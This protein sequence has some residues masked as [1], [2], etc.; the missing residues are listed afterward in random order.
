[1]SAKETS[2]KS[3][4]KGMFSRQSTGDNKSSHKGTI[5]KQNSN[6]DVNGAVRSDGGKHEEHINLKRR[7]VWQICEVHVTSQWEMMFWSGRCKLNMI[8][9]LVIMISTAMH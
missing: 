8:L 6:L 3:T 4:I 2:N 5:E 7:Q 1:M 9:Y